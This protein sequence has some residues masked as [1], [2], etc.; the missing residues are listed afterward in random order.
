MSDVAK[1]R[2][3]RNN[4]S[5]SALHSM[6]LYAAAQSFLSHL[7][8]HEREFRANTFVYGNPAGPRGYATLR[9]SP[10]GT[11]AQLTPAVRRATDDKSTAQI[12]YA[13]PDGDRHKLPHIPP[14]DLESGEWIPSRTAA[15]FENL[16]PDTLSDYRSPKR[17]QFA[18]ADRMN[19]IDRDG[20]IWRRRGSKS[21]H[22]WYYKPSLKDN[23]KN[24]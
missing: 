16:K 2:D 7:P 5:L 21:S 23:S 4:I 20:R 9:N 1:N 12:P 13:Q 18:T 14:L 17:A 10:Y 6:N 24:K 3:G 8:E 11:D 15:K 22:P 19:G